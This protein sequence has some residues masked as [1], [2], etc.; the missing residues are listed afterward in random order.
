MFN[1]YA[2]SAFIWIRRLEKKVTQQRQHRNKESHYCY[3]ECHKLLWIT[4]EVFQTQK[5][6]L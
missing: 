6:L 3:Q 2:M 1:I 4:I 5:S